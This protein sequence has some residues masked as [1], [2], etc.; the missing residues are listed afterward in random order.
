M[1]KSSNTGAALQNQIVRGEILKTPLRNGCF[2]VHH[3]IDCTE[4]YI[5]TLSDPALRAATWL[6]YKQ[7][8]TAKILV[9]ATPN[10]AFNFV[11]DTWSDKNF[12]FPFNKRIPIL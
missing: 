5:E 2:K 6:D 7:Y 11:S 10:G 12:R 9:S 4:I 3:V 1:G 8:N